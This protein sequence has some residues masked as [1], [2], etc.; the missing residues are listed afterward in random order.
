MGVDSLSIPQGRRTVRFLVV[1]LPADKG[2]AVATGCMPEIL[3]CSVPNEGI[4]AIDA[5]SITSALVALQK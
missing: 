3:D 1:F 5:V 2:L 4:P